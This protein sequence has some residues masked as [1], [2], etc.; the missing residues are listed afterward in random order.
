[1]FLKIKKVPILCENLLLIKQRKEEFKKVAVDHRFRWGTKR[2][3]D[4]YASTTI[5][6]IDGLVAAAFCKDGPI[7]YH[8]KEFSLIDDS[9]VCENVSPNIQKKYGSKVAAVLGRALLWRIYDPDQS[10]VVPSEI[11]T[12]V[13]NLFNRVQSSWLEDGDNPITKVPLDVQGDINGN[14]ILTVLTDSIDDDGIPENEDKEQ[15]LNC[16]RQKYNSDLMNRR[17]VNNRSYLTITTWAA[18]IRWST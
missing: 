8:I 15:K 1:L 13:K 16:L 9:W 4:R 7:H 18:G 12:G 2:Q 10:H 11:S 5:P 6:S 14:L 3:Q 17:V